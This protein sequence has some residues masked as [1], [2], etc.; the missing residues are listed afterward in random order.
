MCHT[1]QNGPLN[2]MASRSMPAALI[3]KTRASDF[4]ENDT[5]SF[6][7]L[8]SNAIIPENSLLDQRECP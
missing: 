4:G 1:A 2:R 3:K 6:R 8:L 5:N 7:L